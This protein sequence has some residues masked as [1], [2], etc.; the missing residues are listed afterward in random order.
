MWAASREAGVPE[1]ED[2]HQKPHD[3]TVFERG[4][5]SLYFEAV[6]EDVGNVHRSK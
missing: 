2:H 3:R 5:A 1:L 4:I 6:I